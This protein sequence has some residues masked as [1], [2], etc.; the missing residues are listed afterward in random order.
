MLIHI[1]LHNWLH[2]QCFLIKV[3]KLFLICPFPTHFILLAALSLKIGVSRTR[4]KYL[5]IMQFPL[6]FLFVKIFQEPCCQTLV[7]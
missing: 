6:A 7:L 5:L 3:L 2:Y 1:R 4:I